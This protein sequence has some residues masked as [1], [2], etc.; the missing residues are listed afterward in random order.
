MNAI[1]LAG[2]IGTR[3]RPITYTVPKCLVPIGGKPLLQIWIEALR[4]AG[5]LK[6]LIN[7]HYLARQVEDFVSSLPFHDDIILA[8]EPVLL[9]TAGTL[10]QNHDFFNGEDG[11]LIHADNYCLADFSAFVSAHHARPGYCCMTMMTFT[12]D[13]PERCG[14]VET[15]TVGVVTGFYEKVE[16]PPGNLANGAI[17]AL[18]PQ[19]VEMVM[20]TGAMDFSLEVLPRL[21]NRIF[22][23]HTLDTLVD[24]GTPSDYEKYK[25]FQN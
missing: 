15:D 20:A 3:L 13:K 12:T 11:L 6:I 17:Y 23:F 1:L 19:L 18:S 7:T 2:G 10:R 9:G 8:H 24:I 21:I 5:I 4:R 25:R 16:N 22:T 14:I